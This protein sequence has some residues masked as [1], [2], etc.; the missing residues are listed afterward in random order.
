MAYQ[1]DMLK[2]FALALDPI[3]VG[4]GGIRLG[5]V[6][7]T[8]VREPGTNLPKIPGTSLAGAC[9]TYAAMQ[10]NGKFSHCAGQGQPD[11]ARGY[12]GHC[13]QPD[14]PI[15]VTF[16]FAKGSGASFQ[17]LAQFSDARLVL[18]P[19]HSLAG[20]VWV[21]CP[22][23][24]RDLGITESEPADGHVRV[25][26]G[27]RASGR[28]NLGWLMLDAKTD[29][30]LGDKLPH[31]PGEI[32]SRAVLVSDKMFGHIVNDNLEVRTSVSID[33]STGAAAE[34]ALYTYEAIPRASVLY[35]EVVVSDPK[36]Y[37]IAGQEPLKENGG[38]EKVKETLNNGFALFEC[39]GIG[40][41]NTRGMGRLKV[42][43]LNAGGETGERGES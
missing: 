7:M 20:P 36:F 8:I 28:L 22:G 15:C 25:S 42:L 5:R 41:M 37:Q 3:H 21:T 17:G 33:P 27:V 16:G 43:N 35:F 34:G 11:T 13:G 14:C 24:L 32:K 9:R 18:F 30:S 1:P 10:E 31:V 19:V 23:V 6:D 40:G 38:K 29:F 12:Q 2:Y 39:L 4:T 26:G